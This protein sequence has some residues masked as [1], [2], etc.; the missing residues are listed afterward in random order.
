MKE[1]LVSVCIPAYNSA[2]YIKDTMES[3][4]NQTYQNIELIVVDD[5][6]KDD[7]YEMAKS[8][9]DERIKVYKNEKNLGMVGNWNHC[10]ELASG[11]FLKLIC[12][13][14]M[15]DQNAL[16]K[17]AKAMAEHPTV[18]L[19]ESDTRLVDIYGKKTGAYKRYHKSGLVDGKKVAKKA[20]IYKNFFGAPVN[21][22]MR[23]T[24]FEQ[25]GGFDETFT[26]ILDFDLWV[27]IACTGDIYIIHE[28]LNSFRIRNDSNTGDLINNKQ[29]VYVNEHQALVEKHARS[30]EV[31]IS[32]F[33][34]T[35]SVMIRKLR[36]IA[37]NIYL[38]IFAK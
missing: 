1:P 5:N 8:I 33:E 18:N 3:I 10:L 7:T 28:L 21:N 26:Y 4:L 27:S 38:K 35:L 12:S 22:L 37:I 36:N 2:A 31:S 30:G 32:K 14:D 16:E 17:E 9:K 19:V 29:D 25:V 13:D 15:I 6:S 24:A 20:L 11:E 34:I 23:K